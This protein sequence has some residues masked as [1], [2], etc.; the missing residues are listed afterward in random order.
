M[1]TEKIG[2]I[3][4]ICL[5][6]I[7]VINEL[8][9]NVPNMI[10]LDTKTGS[11]LNII[12]V[13]ILAIIFTYTICKLFKPFYGK[14]ILDVSEYVGGKILKIILGILFILFFLLLSSINLRYFANS[15]KVI[16]FNTS[17]LVYIL[18]F[19][20]VPA[21]YINK[22]GLRA[23]S[24]VN[25]IFL[26]IILASFIF[27]LISS[28]DNFTMV[29][30]FPILGEGF[31]ET[32]LTGS[33]NIF[34]FTGLAYIFFLPALLKDSED[35]KKVSLISIIISS[36]CL[37]LSVLSLIMAFPVITKTDETLSVYL[38]TR[39][40]ELGDFLER[41]DALFIFIWIIAHISFLS[42]TFFYILKIFQKITRIED[43]R[44]LTSSLGLIILGSCLIFKDIAQL[45]F[46]ARYFLKYSTVIFIFGICFGVLILGNIKYRKNENKNNN[47]I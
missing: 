23:I 1:S 34:A 26:P 35:F 18:L 5:M 32:F 47:S 20:L 11:T 9:I 43:S 44:T 14:D 45:K 24:G 15:L 30:I 36:L 40:V 42:L 16:Y 10:I 46:I 6:L 25:L 2:K 29:R 8:I 37:I 27:L 17:P 4:A 12:F 7:I 31:T 22:Y 38:L 41:L 21:L 3:E 33:T 28:Y 13:S 19:F 39:L